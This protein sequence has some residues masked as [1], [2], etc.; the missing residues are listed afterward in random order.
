MR[1]E[2]GA[3]FEF[4]TWQRAPTGTEADPSDAS[5]IDDWIRKAVFNPAAAY[6]AD[7][8]DEIRRKPTDAVVCVDILFGAAAAV[9]AAGC[10]L[11]LLSPHVS[12]RSIPGIPPATSGLAR[13][14]TEKER[15]EIDALKD[16]RSAKL[17][18]FLPAFNKLRFDL[19]LPAL[20]HID[21]HFDRADRVL[22]AISKAF[23]FEADA[24]P[25]NIRYIGPLLDMPAWSAPWQ[26]P[27]SDQQHRP[28]ALIACST[29]AQGQRNL[30]QRV[31][32]GVG[33]VDVEAVA[34]AGPNL[35]VN[36]LRAP[37]NVNVLKS[38]PHD[39]VMKDVSFVISQGGHGT[40]CRALVNDLPLLILPGG[41]D[42]ADNAARVAAK[43]AGL[44]LPTS[45]ST[46]EIAA[47]VK[48]LAINPRYRVEARRLGR[49][50]RADIAACRFAHEVETVMLAARAKRLPMHHSRS[51]VPPVMALDSH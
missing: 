32:D 1:D 19:G 48:D 14:T 35:S 38:A 45:A 41:R 42:Q 31:I 24:L 39:A 25:R 33:L 11:F 28:R 34:T 8:G 18:K 30:I 51:R 13:P 17:N 20:A 40:V 44:R 15:A 12:L 5:E 4:V 23:D 3:E 49:A 36:D 16:R 7:V 43:G 9:E 47:A 6:A 27:W 46:A 2:V 22:L 10:P 21:D 50:I 29:G 26:A 37:Q